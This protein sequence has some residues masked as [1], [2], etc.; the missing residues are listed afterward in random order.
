M[1]NISEVAD[2]HFTHALKVHFHSI[3]KS[4]KTL[5]NVFGP[6]VTIRY[7]T[8]QP[9]K[10]FRKSY[11]SNQLRSWIWWRRHVDHHT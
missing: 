11:S 10:A 9:H 5:K 4:W 1:A 2:F 6:L 3:R 8:C 7:L